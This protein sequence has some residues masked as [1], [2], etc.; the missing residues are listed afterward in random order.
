MV[1][2]VFRIDSSFSSTAKFVFFG[3]RNFF[4][5]SLCTY[6]SENLTGCMYLMSLLLVK[7]F[8]KFGR[9][10]PELFNFECQFFL[11]DKHFAH[12]FKETI[13]LTVQSTLPNHGEFFTNILALSEIGSV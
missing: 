7:K 9:V 11:K 8:V 6:V 10:V 5:R 13:L 1:L 12:F 4:V 3:R 2:T